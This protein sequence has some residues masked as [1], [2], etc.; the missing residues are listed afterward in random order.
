MG[1]RES[2]NEHL[3][4]GSSS[5]AAPASR[6]GWGCAA[7][8]R[9]RKLGLRRGGVR[10]RFSQPLVTE[11]GRGWLPTVTYLRTTLPSGQT[12]LGLPGAVW[13]GVVGEMRCAPGPSR[14]PPLSQG[15]GVRPS[16][17]PLRCCS[18]LTA[19]RRMSQAAPMPESWGM[20][21]FSERT[22]TCQR[23]L[24]IGLSR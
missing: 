24:A 20:V 3:P 10:P 5:R 14:T 13:V 4:P 16:S 15:G 9:A 21:G 23:G 2:D 12:A 19:W 8:G 22:R 18:S 7:E 11:G 1:K 17:S 6:C